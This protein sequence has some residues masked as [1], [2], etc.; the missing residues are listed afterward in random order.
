MSARQQFGSICAE[1][2]HSEGGVTIFAGGII[3]HRVQSMKH[4]ADLIAFWCKQAKAP[5][6]GA[7]IEALRWALDQHAAREGVPHGT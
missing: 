2:V 1:V 4:A 7:M 6:S 3:L 5:C